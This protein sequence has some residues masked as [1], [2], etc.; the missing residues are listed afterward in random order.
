MFYCIHIFIAGG[1]NSTDTIILAAIGVG[2]LV[3]IILIVV[4]AG[5]AMMLILKNR[6]GH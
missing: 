3:I 4:I 6:Q 1:P 5:I 2:A